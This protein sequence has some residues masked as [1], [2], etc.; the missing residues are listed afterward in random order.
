MSKKY[1]ILLIA[2]TLEKMGGVADFCKMLLSHLSSDF[3][4]FHLPVGSRKE[5]EGIIERWMNSCRAIFRLIQSLRKQK[6]DIIQINPSFKSYCL[7]RDSFLILLLNLFNLERRAIVFFHGW[8]PELVEKVTKNFILRK[9]FIQIY[10]N[11]GAII[12]LFDQCRHQLI[13]FGL[14]PQKII[15]MTTMYEECDNNV[16]LEYWL[17][18]SYTGPVQI[19]FMSRLLQEKGVF[20]AAE[21]AKNLIEKGKRDFYLTFAGNGPEYQELKKFISDNNLNEYV[22]A[23]GFISGEKKKN[24]LI[25]SD[26]LLF[27]TYY[28]EGCPVVVLE[29]MGAGLAIVSTSVGAIPEIVKQNENGFIVGSRDPNDFAKVII[30][31]M[32]DRNLL[33][34]IQETNKQKAAMNYEAEVVARKIESIYQSLVI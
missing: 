4:V 34:N 7:V 5:K 17:K 25:K 30:H 1:Q 6:F 31:L 33:K 12:V 10:R 26:I 3:H 21:A 28:G 19:L 29:A 32:E 14:N 23:P 9:L 11:I 15:K 22:D 2:P 8:D 18:K 13:S 20:I 16:L 24:L 27:P